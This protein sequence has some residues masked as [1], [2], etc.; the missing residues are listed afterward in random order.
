MPM[1]TLLAA[2][3]LACGLPLV[4]A[5]AQAQPAA[6]QPAASAAAQPALTGASQ[7]AAA[8]ALPGAGE[9]TQQLAQLNADTSTPNLQQGGKGAAVLR[10]QILLDRAWFSPGEIDGNYGSNMT[11]AVSAFQLSRGLT[12]SGKIDAATWSALQEQQPGPLFMAYTLTEQDVA[13]PYAPIPKDAMEQAKLPALGYQSVVEA[14]AERFHTS[15]KLLEK[16]NPGRTARAGDTIVVADVTRGKPAPTGAMRIVIDKS[17]K[18][19]YLVDA[20]G[21]PVAGFPVSFGGQQDPLPLGQMKIKSEVKDPFF[22][23]NPELLRTAKPTD[24]KVRL[25]PGPNNPVGVM[26]LGL[27]KPHWGIHGTNEPSQ[28]AR[29]D[30]NGCVRLTNWD[31]LR[32][33]SVVGPGTV[34]EVQS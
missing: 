11:R 6:P 1:R 31:V 30:T 14:L 20:G 5:A 4:L 18:M 23:Y 26:W 25:Q 21:K 12:A 28:M 2:S 15:P 22:N 33:A 8:Q 7:P 32:L 34:V 24:T 10:A 17:D 29:V 19:L 16:M 27:S 3:A 13:G 9:A